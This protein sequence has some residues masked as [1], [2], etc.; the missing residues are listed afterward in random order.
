MITVVI[1][2]VVATVHT[3][4]QYVQGRV[5]RGVFTKMRLVMLLFALLL[6]IV[7]LTDFVF[8]GMG[9]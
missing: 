2:L 8:H 3:H 9:G 6:V 4:W 5:G 1:L 7:F